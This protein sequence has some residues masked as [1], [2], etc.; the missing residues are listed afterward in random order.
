MNFTIDFYHHID[1][2][3]RAIA[4]PNI[5]KN[6]KKLFSISSQEVI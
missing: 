6:Y 2:L 3:L 1:L 5:V 4:Q